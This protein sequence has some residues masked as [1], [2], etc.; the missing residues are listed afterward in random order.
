MVTYSVVSGKR[1]SF[2]FY[3]TRSSTVIF[4]YRQGFQIK[5]T[6][7]YKEYTGSKS[8]KVKGLRER[9]LYNLIPGNDW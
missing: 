3:K 9:F 8:H 5:Y 4:S 7:N 2:T 1:S 6:Y